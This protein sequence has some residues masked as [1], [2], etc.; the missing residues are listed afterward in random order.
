M[1]TYGYRYSYNINP[2]VTKLCIHNI[3]VAYA[4][5]KHPV[6]TL[7]SYTYCLYSK[8][9]LLCRQCNII[10]IMMLCSWLQS[11]IVATLFCNLTCIALYPIVYAVYSNSGIYYIITTYIEANRMYYIALRTKHFVNF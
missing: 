4:E 7:Y 6:A 2:I 3:L 10:I 8:I 1:L 5:F 9:I 11:N